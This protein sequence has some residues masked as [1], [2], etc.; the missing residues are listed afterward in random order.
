[1]NDGAGGDFPGIVPTIDSKGYLYL[2]EGTGY[3]GS[4]YRNTQSTHFAPAGTADEAVLV[5]PDGTTIPIAHTSNY[6]QSD[7]EGYVKQASHVRVTATATVRLGGSDRSVTRTVDLPIPWAIFD[8]TATTST[9]AEATIMMVTDPAGGPS[10]T[11]DTLYAISSESNIVNDKGSSDNSYKIG[12]FHYNKDYLWWVFFGTDVRNSTNN[13]SS[14]SGKFVIPAVTDSLGSTYEPSTYPAKSWA[15]TLVG[16]ARFQA[17]KNAVVRTWFANQEK[18]WWGYRFLTGDEDNKTTVNADNGNAAATQ[19]SRDVRLFRTATGSQPNVQVKNLTAMSPSTST[20]LAHAFANAYAQLALTSDAGSTF[21]TANVSSGGQ[22]GTENPIPPCRSSFM[23]AFTD[24]IANDNGLGTGDPYASGTMGTGNTNLGS[25]ATLRP[26]SANFNIWTLAGV[27]AQY[28]KSTYTGPGKG[29]Y[30]IET[31]APWLITTRGATTSAPRRARTMTVAMS[32]AG[33]LADPTSGKSDLFRAALYGNPNQDSWNLSTPP[34]DPEDSTTDSAVNPYFFDATDVDRLSN[35]LTAIL[36]EVTKASASVAAPSS[37]LVG[38]SLGNQVYLGLFET[39]DG[40]RWRGDLLMAGLLVAPAG[41]TFLDGDGNVA[42]EINANNAV[43]SAHDNVFSNKARTW[44]TR[45][46]F[47]VLPGTSSLVEFNESNTALTNTIVDAADSASRQAYIRFMRGA[48]A[49]A[50][51]DATNDNPR[52]DIFGD[53]ISSSPAVLEYP[54]D[55]L[56]STVSPKLASM[57][58]AIPAGATP[59]FRVIFVGDNQGIFHAFAELGWTTTQSVTVTNTDGTTTTVQAKVPK[60]DVDEIWA[61]LPGEHLKYIKQLRSKTSPHRYRVDGSP[62]LYFKD[63]PATGQVIGDGLVNGSDTVRVIIG[64]RKGGRSYY[65]F[66]FKDLEKVVGNTGSVLAWK[67]V[68]DD[69]SAST[70]DAQEKVIARMGFSTSNPA[71]GRVE[72]TLYGAKDLVFLGGGMSTNSVDNAFASTYGSGTKLG[73]SLIAFDVVNGPSSNLYTWN[74]TDSAFT[75]KFGAMGPVSAGVVPFEFFPGSQ[76][77]QRVYFAD[78]PSDGNVDST[79]P[80]GAAIWALGSTST[81]SAPNSA[82]R[83]DSSNIDDWTS[84]TVSTTQGIRRILQTPTGWSITS[85]P[86]PFLLKGPYPAIRTSDPKTLPAAVG[87]V[88]G[89]GDRNDPMDNDAIDPQVK[90]GGTITAYNNWLTVAFDRQDS[91]GLSGV[92][93]VTATDL[94]TT[95]IQVGKTSSDGDLADLTTVSAFTGIFN[96]YSVDPTSSSYFLKKELGYKLN[97]G[98][99]AVHTSSTYFFPKVITNTVVL[100]G[101]LFFSGFTPESSTSG[102]CQGVGFTNTYRICN[103]MQPTF[104]SGSNVAK[105]NT[106]NGGDPTCTGKVLTFPN[107]PGELTALGTAAVIQ[108]GQGVS[109]TG[110]ASTISNTG[111]QVGG[112][113]GNTSG[114][115][116]KPRSWRIIR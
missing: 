73:R 113:F 1:M 64:E 11:P 21:G 96:T 17:L 72:T 111:A 52:N 38:L 97:V 14:D 18:V 70:T 95:G 68:P 92:S 109:T 20:P 83:L 81:A 71:V 51:I 55:A 101:V 8:P 25:L 13:G 39:A 91:G 100:N 61:F 23:V 36:A 26:G 44:K 24:G 58:G 106:F 29:A 28:K 102:A 94:N 63:V 5:R 40:P 80:R 15:N 47:T 57:K 75:T 2:L 105:S 54:L 78:T 48:E 110:T 42:Q 66:D 88:A 27:A 79:T 104:N 46:I 60:G 87:V 98:S 89:T 115:G 77:T 33:A 41:I 67:V 69:I 45:N 82:I 6:T 93:G 74:F 31:Y 4:I 49:A 10:V 85:A 9:N 50:E 37:P 116:F 32:V 103:V 30:S 3:A 12:R 112:S 108:S 34:F 35:S 43:W 76:R 65:A 59:H 19:V 86:T 53:I 84:T 16:F 56:T 107:L 90:A 114:F 99:A 7:L 62:Y 22:S